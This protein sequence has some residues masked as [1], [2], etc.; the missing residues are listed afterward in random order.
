MDFIMPQNSFPRPNLV[1]VRIHLTFYWWCPSQ[2]HNA[3]SGISLTR[4]FI[5]PQPL[6]FARTR[7]F[8][9]YNGFCWHTHFSLV[10]IAVPTKPCLANFVKISWF[11]NKELKIKY[12]IRLLCSA[13]KISKHIFPRC[14][15]Q[16]LG[17]VCPLQSN[18][19]RWC[20]LCKFWC[21][22]TIRWSRKALAVFI[23][24]SLCFC[25]QG[26]HRWPTRG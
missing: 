4:A 21:V 19:S 18:Y 1:P 12:K 3:I 11:E 7:W 5:I 13:R 26:C 25:S 23:W 24:T 17:P 8:R 10:R 15:F 20:C 16:S 22:L 9:I 2:L 14:C 6:A